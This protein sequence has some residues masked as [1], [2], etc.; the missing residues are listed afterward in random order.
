MSIKYRLLETQGFAGDIRGLTASEGRWIVDKLKCQVYP[1]L[2]LEPHYGP[3]I[4]RLKSIRPTIW[5]Y[6]I[7]HFRLFYHVDEDRK[8]VF[9]DAIEH[10]RE[11]YR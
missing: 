3:N 8:I 7:G 10:R 6:R 4:A 2:E 9:L 5:R 1:Q 11:A